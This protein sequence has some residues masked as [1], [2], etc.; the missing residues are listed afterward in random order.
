MPQQIN[1]RDIIYFSQLPE[2]I[3]DEIR[4]VLRLKK[5]QAGEIL[6]NHGDAGDELVIVKQGK[7]SIY[8]PAANQDES[9]QP[10]RIFTPG[11]VLGEMSLIDKQPRSASARAEVDSEVLTLDGDGFRQLLGAHPELAMAVM[12]GLNDRIRYTTE[13][14]GEVREWVKR[15]AVGDYQTESI[16]DESYQDRTI[17]ALAAEFAQ[18]AARVQQR[19]E[20]LRQE[21]TQ[22]RIEIDEIKRKREAQRIMDTDYYK[23]LKAKAKA[24]RSQNQ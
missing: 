17:A 1:L 13:F 23:D 8:V 22:L 4:T 24:L 15:I 9:I 6:F 20:D 16:M 14:L 5:L 10:I 21:V 11:E 7:I 3:L 2:G 19:E 18:M 12:A